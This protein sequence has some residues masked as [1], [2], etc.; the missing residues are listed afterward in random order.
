MP[1]ALTADQ[2]A[3]LHQYWPPPD[4]CLC[5]HEKRV[6][7]LVRENERLRGALR[8]V[9]STHAAAKALEG[10]KLDRI[11][12]RQHNRRVDAAVKKADAALE[13]KAGLEVLVE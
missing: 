10:K 3:L 2:H 13:E 8:E 12:L 6:K 5:N 9:L 4:C 11:V 1:K 7:E